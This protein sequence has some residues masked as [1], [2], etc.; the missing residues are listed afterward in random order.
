MGENWFRS[1]SLDALGHTE[2][3]QIVTRLRSRLEL[4]GAR[5][6]KMH[7]MLTMTV[8]CA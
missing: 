1:G 5:P 7:R 8:S 4:V 6:K 3:L 2:C